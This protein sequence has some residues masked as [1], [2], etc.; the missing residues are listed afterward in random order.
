MAPPAHETSEQDTSNRIQEG[1]CLP[2]EDIKL[3]VVAKDGGKSEV[4]QASV[5]I[6]SM[7]ALGLFQSR[8]TTRTQPMHPN[9]PL[10]GRDL[11]LGK[12][13]VVIA[14]PGAFTPGAFH[15]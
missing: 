1:A 11:F 5:L 4:S 15:V 7:S 10:S 6:D 14:I 2:L 13:V 12:R 8:L 3:Y 9:Q